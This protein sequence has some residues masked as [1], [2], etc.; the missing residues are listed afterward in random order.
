MAHE[1]LDARQSHIEILLYQQNSQCISGRKETHVQHVINDCG[2]V[3]GIVLTSPTQISG[4]KLS[5]IVWLCIVATI[6]LQIPV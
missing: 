3:Y 6:L 1:C 4:Y 2:Y 5:E